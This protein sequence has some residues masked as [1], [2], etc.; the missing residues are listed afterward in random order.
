MRAK[1]REQY[2]RQSDIRANIEAYSVTGVLGKASAQI[3]E[4]RRGPLQSW[5]IHDVTPVA[6]RQWR[7]AYRRRR[8]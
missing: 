6:L 2:R 3:P 5:D 1:Q 7:V 4:S 8:K